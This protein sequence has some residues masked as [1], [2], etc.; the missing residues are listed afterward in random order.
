MGLRWQES[1]LPIWWCM[2]SAKRMSRHKDRDLRSMWGMTITEKDLAWPQETGV[3]PA[4]TSKL[5]V[6]KCIDKRR[7]AERLNPTKKWRGLFWHTETWCTI[8]RNGEHE[9][10]WS[11]IHGKICQCIQKKNLGITSIN[12]TFSVESY[13]TIVLTWKMFMASSM[14]AAIHLGPDFL[15]NSEIN[16]NTRFEN[17]ENL[18]K[19]TQQSIK[20]DSEEILNVRSLDYSSPSWTRATLFNDK[21]I[22]WAKAKTSVYAD[23]VLCIGR[24]DHEPGAAEERWK[25][26]IEFLKKYPDAEAIEFES[27]NVPG[28]TTFI[29]LQ[30]P[31]NFKDQIIF[32][33]MFNAFLWKSDD[34]NCI[35]NAEKVKNYAKRF[36]P[37]HWTFLG[38]GSE[39][40]WHRDSHGGQW[41]RAANKMV[42][43]FKETGHLVFISTSAMSRGILKQRRGRSTSHFN[44]DSVNS[45]LLFQ[46][47]HSVNQLGVY[48]FVTDWCN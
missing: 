3:V 33:S 29:V 28:F 8:T 15:N 44:G 48:A 35:S 5:K 13:K 24:N 16:K 37:G 45:E 30:E 42:Q 26:Q 17:I 2:V 6:P 39:K 38:P 41:D 46:T 11:S 21:A 1:D 19:I 9:I 14:M 20:E 18:F 31:E 43:Q 12:T 36:L 10:L 7:W 47:V 22:K 34:Q 25:G 32:M 23:S 40:R 4:R 27:K